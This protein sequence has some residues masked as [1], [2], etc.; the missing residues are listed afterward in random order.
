MNQKKECL[1]MELQITKDDVLKKNVR[2]MGAVEET[3]ETLV[4]LPD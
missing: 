1:I 3:V 4:N 2:Y